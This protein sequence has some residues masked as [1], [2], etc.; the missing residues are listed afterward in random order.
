MISS[1]NDTIAAIS[2]PPGEGGIGIVRLSGPR[3]MGITNRIFVPTGKS[4]F[5]SALSHTV[6]HGVIQDPDS[7]EI[8]DEVLVNVMRGPRSYTAE[9]VVEINCHGGAMPLKKVME[10]CLT[11]GVRVAEPGEFTKRAF[12]NGR[13]DLAQAEAVLDI[14]KAQTDISRKI[15]AEQ[16]NG[17]FSG[18]IRG[19]KDRIIGLLAQIELT[20]DFSQEDVEFPRITEISEGIRQVKDKIVNILMTADK[21]MILREGLDVVICGRPNVG[22]S[23]LMNALLRHER[24]IVTP[25]AGTTRDVIEESIEIAGVKIKISDTAGIIET[26]NRVEIEGIKRSRAKL[27]DADIVIFMLD[28]SCGLS[29]KDEEI[30][31]AIKHKS[32]VIVANKS[33]IKRKLD[34]NAAVRRFDGNP[35]ISVSALKREG[36][37]KVEDAVSGKMFKGSRE[38]P[39][40]YVVTSLRHK[41]L[42]KNA[43]NCLD[44]ACQTVLN[45][46]NAELL[47]SDLNSAIHEL[48]LII[49]ESVEDDIL[50][51]IFSQFCIGK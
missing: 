7:G 13:I 1:N 25:I 50:D 38:V 26:R 28:N 10:L 41:Q 46:Y 51:R 17:V 35:I 21:G 9:D 40:G 30:Y 5:L 45:S 43:E 2:T 14:I 11:G 18:E 6:H 27:R 23:S 24:V 8:A 20:I 48:G 39:G 12:L 29:S 47:A 42:L 49:G 19:L 37:D 31:D 3:A 44:R 32:L 4:D 36:L 22:K 15:A 16:L 34:I 33:D